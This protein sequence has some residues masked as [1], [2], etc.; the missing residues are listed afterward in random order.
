MGSLQRFLKLGISELSPAVLSGECCPRPLFIQ[1]PTSDADSYRQPLP[2]GESDPEGPGHE[3]ALSHRWS[4]LYLPGVTGRDVLGA[5]LVL[6]SGKSPVLLGDSAEEA[7]S[8][9]RVHPS[10]WQAACH[11]RPGFVGKGE[12]WGLGV[13]V[14][15]CQSCISLEAESPQ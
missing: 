15:A 1:G 14:K 12:V 10:S 3:G 9:H 4:I 5:P 2:T 8:Q 7:L 11:S 13:G 6:L